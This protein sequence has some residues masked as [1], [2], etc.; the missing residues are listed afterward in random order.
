MNLIG[1]AFVC[2]AA[3]HPLDLKGRIPGLGLPPTVESMEEGGNRGDLKH[4]E[5]HHEKQTCE[6]CE[7]FF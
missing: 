5:K 6:M 3:F 7:Y 2:F 4:Q 1:L